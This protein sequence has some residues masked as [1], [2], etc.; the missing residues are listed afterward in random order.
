MV[1]MPKMNARTQLSRIRACA[2]DEDITHILDNVARW[3][4]DD[5]ADALAQCLCDIRDILEGR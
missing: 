1:R 3:F 4:E 5:A 2:F